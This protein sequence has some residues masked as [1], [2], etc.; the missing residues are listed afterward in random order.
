MADKY[1]IGIDIGGTKVNIGIVRENG[2]VFDKVRIPSTGAKQA[3][4]FVVEI[5]TA[6][7][8]LLAKNQLNL[9]DIYFIGGGQ[10]LQQIEVSKELQKH[11]EF[12]TEERDR[13]AVFLGICG[14]RKGVD[15][16]G[17]HQDGLCHSLL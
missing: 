5:C 3:E 17:W 14:G 2:E 7:K 9:N 8:E 13:M 15:S 6:A 4:G 1:S 11:K 10:D 16:D 12:F